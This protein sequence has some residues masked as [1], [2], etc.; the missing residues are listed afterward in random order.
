MLDGFAN[1]ASYSKSST[2]M[3]PLAGMSVEAMKERNKRKGL[4]GDFAKSL[5]DV[6]GDLENTKFLGNLREE[7][8]ATIGGIAATRNAAVQQMANLAAKYDIDW[9][10]NNVDAS[11]DN[12]VK[13]GRLSPEEYDILYEYEL[14]NKVYK[15][16]INQHPDI[17]NPTDYTSAIDAGVSM[18]DTGNNPY[19]TQHNQIIN[20][21]FNGQNRIPIDVNT[22]PTAI[23]QALAAKGIDI[24]SLGL[25]ISEDEEGN[26]IL[27][28]NYDHADKLGKAYEAIKP[29]IEK[30]DMLLNVDPSILAGTMYTKIP[31]NPFSIAG[32]RINNLYNKASKDLKNNIEDNDYGYVQD[33]L[34]SFDSVVTALANNRFKQNMLLGEDV[35]PSDINTYKKMYEDMLSG[36]GNVTDKEMSIGTGIN[37]EQIIQEGAAKQAI[38]Q[39][40]R[41]INDKGINGSVV[42]N[43]KNDITK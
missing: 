22:N 30:D 31:N 43:V 12:L 21:L 27:Y 19:I 38:M 14:S 26:E 11:M 15:N 41:M 42:R 9:D 33:D 5:F 8:D 7:P 35:K 1:V 10:G 13:S 2:T 39:L 17:K 4:N 16:I 20:G 3:T 18:I 25:T 23:S 34:Y 32:Q 28:M 36:F 24:E 6:L 37:S 40:I 29:Y